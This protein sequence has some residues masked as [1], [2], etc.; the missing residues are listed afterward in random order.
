MQNLKILN[1]KEIKKI[2]EILKQQFGFKE[3]LD[4]VFLMN[5]RNRL[6]LINKDLAKLNLETLRIDSIGLYFGEYRRDEVRLS[7]EGG[8]MIGKKV[9][10]NIIELNDRE[11]EEWLTGQDI[12]KKS[13]VSG[14]VILKHKEDILG[15]G[16]YKE[17]KILNYV[18]K[19][20]RLRVVS[21]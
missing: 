19:E 12:H 6:Y 2:T 14:F 16:R 13:N 10:K 21:N 20:R 7:I 11:A 5:Q 15:C 17:E 9:T 8:Q 18:P 3:K 4:Y 1:N